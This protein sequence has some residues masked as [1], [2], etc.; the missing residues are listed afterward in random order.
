M[1]SSERVSVCLN[2]M[3]KGAGWWVSP[4]VSPGFS[5][6]TLGMGSVIALGGGIATVDRCLEA[7]PLGSWVCEYSA[8]KVLRVGGGWAGG[9]EVVVVVGKA[10]DAAADRGDVCGKWAGPGLAEVSSVSVST[11]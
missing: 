7:L 11:K 1:S 6:G 10:W 8:S 3:V 4:G 9:P 5:E 2:L